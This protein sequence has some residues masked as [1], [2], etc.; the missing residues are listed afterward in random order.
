M[1]RIEMLFLSL[2]AVFTAVFV[3]CHVYT[4]GHTAQ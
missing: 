2:F 4:S 3:V 1:E